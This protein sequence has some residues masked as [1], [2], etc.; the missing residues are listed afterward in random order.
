VTNSQTWK[1]WQRVVQTLV[2]K[3]RLIAIVDDEPDILKLYQDFFT[4]IKGISIFTFTDPLMAL[5]HFRMNKNEYVLVI[6]DLRMPNLDGLE[7]VKLIKDLN[8]LVRTILMTA[9][10]IKDDLFQEYLREEIINDIL[11]KPILLPDL[12]D[13]VRKQLR[14]YSKLK[15]L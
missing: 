4:K 3:K 2:V 11:Q 8:P 5:E 14:M 12:Y 7:L 13:Q 6:W 9:F 10:A 15:R 1:E